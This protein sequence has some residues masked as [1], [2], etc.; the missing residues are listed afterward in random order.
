[1]KISIFKKVISLFI[2][3][4]FLFTSTLYGT[5]E[6]SNQTVNLSDLIKEAIMYGASDDKILE[7]ANYI[8]SYIPENN[9]SELEEKRLRIL[10]DKIIN[11]FIVKKNLFEIKAQES[12]AIR[13]LNNSLKASFLDDKAPSLRLRKDL[14]S[15]NIEDLI[16]SVLLEKKIYESNKSKGSPLKV[17][18]KGFEK[19]KTKEKFKNLF[20]KEKTKN[21]NWEKTKTALLYDFEASLWLNSLKN[22]FKTLMFYEH[23]HPRAFEKPLT[24]YALCIIDSKDLTLCTSDVVEELNKTYEEY[25]TT[26]EK[27][28][29]YSL[30]DSLDGLCEKIKQVTISNPMY[31]EMGCYPK[32]FQTLGN[33]NDNGQIIYE[34]RFRKTPSKKV[35]FPEQ[36]TEKIGSDR[37]EAVR[38]K[39]DNNV[40]NEVC[41]NFSRSILPIQSSG[42]G[43]LLLSENSYKL[44][45]NIYSE[46]NLKH[47]SKYDA[48]IINLNNKDF[49]RKTI[50]ESKENILE[51]ISKINKDFKKSF[52]N[53]HAGVLHTKKRKIKKKLKKN[54]KELI[55]LHPIAVAQT[56]ISDPSYIPTVVV[57]LFKE[58][59][60]DKKRKSRM[61][62][63]VRIGAYLVG[64]MLGVV[65]FVAP[66]IGVPALSGYVG[67][68]S[69]SSTALFVAGAGYFGARTYKEF[70]L[71]NDIVKVIQSNNG[72]ILSIHEMNEA[73]SN[74]IDL[75]FETAINGTFLTLGSAMSILAKG[76]K[77]KAPN[78][79]NSKI[80]KNKI[81]T[82]KTSENKPKITD[83]AKTLDKKIK[84]EAQ[85]KNLE[86]TLETT[87][88]IYTKGEITPFKR[89]RI[90]Y[91]AR[92]ITDETGLFYPPEK[93]GP[94]NAFE[95]LK[96]TNL[97][98]YINLSKRKLYDLTI[99]E[100][101]KASVPIKKSLQGQTGNRV[102]IIKTEGGK[103]YFVKDLKGLNPKIV[104]NEIK[105]AYWYYVNSIG[106]RTFLMKHKAQT[107]LFNN[108]PHYELVIRK[109][110]G[111]NIKDLIR[112]PYF[113]SSKGFA[114]KVPEMK[115]QIEFSLGRKFSSVEEAY[116]EFSKAVFQDELLLTKIEH[117]RKLFKNSFKSTDDVQFMLQP[118]TS[119]Q[120][121][122]LNFIDSGNNTFLYKYGSRG[123]NNTIALSEIDYMMKILKKMSK[124]TPDNMPWIVGQ[125]RT[126]DL[127][128][129]K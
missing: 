20:R 129:I 106:P 123:P 7:I 60:K 22:S 25:K 49:I 46:N 85:T 42:I 37:T 95:K 78:T 111:I 68:L 54:I 44:N 75:A 87:T 52:K 80:L 45:C 50:K 91:E 110:P 72:D 76:T 112:D 18:L 27:Y 12:E 41:T 24:S 26:L 1:M 67:L 125:I 56:L 100:I 58:I 28:K 57:P 116:I 121:T 117:A 124:T 62:T 113:V 10:Q 66:Y 96:S 55:S 122:K 73:H 79:K 71:Y 90:K 17:K 3:F 65:A 16:N 40:R 63:I 51:H 21:N 13:L 74:A 5:T 103:I 127:M 23:L 61:D 98:D 94:I 4:C 97:E 9:I 29:N 82:P 64:G 31:E 99:E 109:A 104:L 19:L 108:K 101:S 38:E 59:A 70:K 84:L 128:F 14:P 86:P 47:I 119:R 39:M 92:R 89:I 36:S 107:G 15:F 88:S 102:K 2:I 32:W 105:S 83:P 43:T 77:L 114:N 34:S 53:A 8:D 11:Y 48:K 81:K 93:G 115:A 6:E 69:I 126:G 118:K 30:Q 120:V 33:V 35:I